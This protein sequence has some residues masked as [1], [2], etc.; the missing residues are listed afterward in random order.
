MLEAAC[1]SNSTRIAQDVNYILDDV[2]QKFATRVKDLENDNKNLQE[3]IDHMN[4]LDSQISE[5]FGHIT[6]QDEATG[7]L[8]SVIKN[9]EVHVQSHK[10]RLDQINQRLEA[11]D[12]KFD[13]LKC[14]P[15][16]NGAE[17]CRI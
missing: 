3:K 2:I 9:H 4:N 8:G 6:Q 11:F 13:N 17:P 1:I 7:A 5:A 14:I 15:T 12:N 10:A 16:K